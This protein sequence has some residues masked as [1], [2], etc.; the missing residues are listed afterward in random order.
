MKKG[1]IVIASVLKPLDDTRMTEKMAMSLLKLG[2]GKVHVIGYGDTKSLNQEIHFHPLGHFS[3]LSF[4]RMCTPWRVLAH[5]LAIRPSAMVITT[6]ELLWVATLAT[7]F[8]QTKAYYDVR[9]NYR[10]NILNTNAFPVFLRPLLGRYV[11]LKEWVFA[12]I[13]HHFILAEK[14]YRDE[15]G[16]IGE[17]FT[18]IENKSVSQKQTSRNSI[19]NT[20]HLVFSGTLDESTGVLDAIEMTK[21]LYAENQTIKLTIVGYAALPDVRKKIL[22][23]AKLHPFIELLG[24]STLVPHAKIEEMIN[25]ADVGIIFYQNAPHTRNCIPTKLYEYLA[26]QLPILYDETATWASL[27][28]DNQGGI[29]LNFKATN[30]RVILEKLQSSKFYTKPPQ[31]V[32]W[33]S[34]EAKLFTVLTK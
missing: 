27:V 7:W 24:I 25:E 13:I 1:S 16:F 30:A 5:V 33:E 32:T 20:I 17:R 14:C 2:V 28:S 8:F 9:E 11:R 6:H 29:S 22:Q 15:L 12:P 31:N 23:E 18:V 3:R 21:Q 19:G 4:T 34:E 26:H 10:L